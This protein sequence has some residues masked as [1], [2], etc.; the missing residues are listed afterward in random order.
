MVLQ[1]A[2]LLPQL[3]IEHHL[4]NENAETLTT[5]PTDLRWSTIEL[6]DQVR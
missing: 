2:V 1:A 4:G 3:L 5:N 6:V